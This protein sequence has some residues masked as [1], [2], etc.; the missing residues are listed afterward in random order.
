MA[1][2]SYRELLPHRIG[3]GFRKPRRTLPIVPRIRMSCPQLP[4][5]KN[6]PNID[7]AAEDTRIEDERTPGKVVDLRYW[8]QQARGRTGDATQI[9]RGCK[10]GELPH[11]ATYEIEPQTS[12]SLV[13]QNETTH[14]A[15]GLVHRP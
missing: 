13:H 6:N 4:Q 12:A 3:N 8:A 5:K 2:C 7:H 15:S 1:T 11:R 10:R 9:G 14:R